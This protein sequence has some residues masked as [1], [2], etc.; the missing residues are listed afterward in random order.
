[1]LHELLLGLLLVILKS[2]YPVERFIPNADGL[3]QLLEAL[4]AFNQLAPGKDRE[5]VDDVTWPGIRTCKDG[6]A[7]P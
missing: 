5:E 4:D 2:D 1:L 7:D 3:E 6:T